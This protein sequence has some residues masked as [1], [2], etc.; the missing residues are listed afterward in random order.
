LPSLPALP[1]LPLRPI[2]AT[3]FTFFFFYSSATHRHLPSSPTPTLFRSLLVGSSAGGVGAGLTADL[4][5]RNV[6]ASVERFTLLDDSGPRSEEHT[7][8][9]QSL[10]NI[11]CRLLLEKKKNITNPTQHRRAYTQRLAE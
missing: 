6:P 8:E 4:V 9:L 10:T 5:A 2:S 1:L 3:A 7:S 11:V